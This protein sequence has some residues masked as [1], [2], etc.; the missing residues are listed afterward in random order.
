MSTAT[1]LITA[2]VLF[3]PGTLAGAAYALSIRGAAAETAGVRAVLA[4]SAHE[5]AQA[6]QDGTATPPGG[7]QPL[8]E[9]TPVVRL[10][11][12]INLAARRAA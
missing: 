12:V 9:P 4:L 10:A 3:G 11:P 5:R 2:A 8:P 1:D 6:E 7:G